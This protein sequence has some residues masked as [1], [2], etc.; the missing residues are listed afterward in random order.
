MK[1]LN[2]VW[3][4][5]RH[6][7]LPRGEARFNLLAALVCL[8]TCGTLAL[9]FHTKPAD[10]GLSSS[11]RT[12]RNGRLSLMALP[13][14]AG[15][16]GNYSSEDLQKRVQGELQTSRMALEL[17]VAMLE[18]GRKRM[19]A[20]PD[21]E[22]VFVRQERLE[23]GTLLDLQTM[24]LKLR[25]QPLSIYMKWIEGGDVG[26]ELLYIDGE[27]DNRMIVKLGGGKKLL[28]AVKVDPEGSLAMAEA[29]HP[30]TN[31]GLMNLCDKILVYRRRDLTTR[32]GVRWQLVP[33]Q[34]FDSRPCHCFI[35][36]YE[37][38]SVEALYRK[39]LTY[40]D[41]ELSVPI[42][43][44]TYGWPVDESLKDDP[45]QLDEQTLLEYYAYTGVRLDRRLSDNAFDKGNADY[46]FR[47]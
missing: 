38:P 17:H 1:H 7:R 37:S 13:S 25:H 14:A 20:I 45:Q 33:D 18:L 15:K 46:H 24:E 21:Y 36:E 8:I 12:L 9:S 40:I 26:R 43:L 30:V 2:Y 22:A 34:K 29:R 42:C 11:S 10:A 4:L 16:G 5:R 27:N 31:A 47:R 6:V 35:V 41:Q 44:K 39:S 19:E 32:T 23:G 28:P 3:S